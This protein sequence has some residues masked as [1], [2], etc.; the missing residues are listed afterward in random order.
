MDLLNRRDITRII[1]DIETQQNRE[2]RENEIKAF[3]I[4]S[5]KLNYHVE[6]RLKELYPQTYKS[7]SIADLNLARKIT[8][9]RAN[10]YKTSPIRTLDN[11]AETELYSDMLKSMG[12]SQIW[13]QYD[14]Y[15][16]LHRYS[17]I[18]FNYI[19]TDEGPR[20]IPRPLYPGQFTRV[21]ND[22]GETKVFVVNFPTSEL[23]DFQGDGQDAFI[24]DSITDN[25]TK[26]YAMWTED[27][28]VVVTVKEVGEKFDVM[29]EDIPGNAEMVNE[30]GMIP[31]VFTQDGDNAALPILN[32]ITDQTIEF[33]QQYSVMLTGASVQTFGHLVLSHPEDQPVPGEIYNSL[34]TY[35]KLPQRSAGP[36]TRLDY[37][38]PNP[39]LDAQLKVIMNYG[40]QIITEHLGESQ[41]LEGSNDFASG[42]DRL[43]AMSDLTNIIESNRELYAKAEN[44]FYQLVKR[45]YEVTNSFTF[46]SDE[47][48]VQYPK[49]KPI[50]SE[51]EILANIEK[52]LD[53]GLIE[54]HEAL[55]MLNPNMSE[56]AAREKIEKINT[57]KINNLNTFFRGADADNEDQN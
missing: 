39:A 56:D 51:S 3:E 46:R 25:E 29:Y 53:L 1:Q 8:D 10:A 38:A 18:W 27:Q 47:L 17:C 12:M 14:V 34:F 55:L 50:Q 4:Y 31:A 5:G 37:L 41:N 30:L 40:H 20:L 23:F 22:I 54:K 57:E 2:R 11:D 15:Y 49:A 7:F 42:L 33:N 9:K 28:H 26:R 21:V 45:F 36:E 13:Q 32:P 24:Q 44:D 48:S 43:I 52:K 35:S 6:Q 19:F 16:N